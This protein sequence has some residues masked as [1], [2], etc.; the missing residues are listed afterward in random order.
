MSLA[1]GPGN[2]QMQADIYGSW[3]IVDWD[4][5][6][7]AGALGIFGTLFGVTVGGVIGGPIG[8]IIGGIIGGIIPVIGVIVGAS[9]YKPHP[10]DVQQENCKILVLD[11]MHVRQRCLQSLDLGSNPVVGRIDPDELFAFPDG[12]VMRGGAKL[13]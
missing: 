7:C 12:L 3:D 6:L 2:R 11:D 1:G 13:G 4:V 8:A 9:T 10:S 5:A